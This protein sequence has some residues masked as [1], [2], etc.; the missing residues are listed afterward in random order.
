M[1]SRLVTVVGLMLAGLLVV[2]GVALSQGPGMWVEY[3]GNPI[4]D[5]LEADAYYPTVLHDP[6]SSPF[7]G[8]GEASPFKMW[9]DSDLQ[10]LVSDDGI[11]WTKVGDML[12]GTVTGLPDGKVRH[13]LVEYYA[14][15]FAGGNDGTNPSGATMYYR[16]WFWHTD[17]LYD[18]AA[19]HYAESP[20]GRAWYNLQ[21]LQNGAVPIVTGD[22]PD[23]HRGSYGPCDVLYHPG[24]SNTGTDW[25]FWMY[26]DGT[27]GGDEAIG[28]GFSADG[29]IWTGYDAN[30]DGNAEPVM[31]GTYIAGGWDENY[32]S[33]ATVWRQGPTDYRMWYS[34]GIDTMNHGIGYA[35]SIDGFNWTRDPDNPIFH[36]DD[37]G[38]PWRVSRTYTPAVVRVGNLWLMW[39]SGENGG[40][41][42][43]GVTYAGAGAPEPSPE[44]DKTVDP[45]RIAVGQETTF[46]ITVSNSTPDTAHDIVVTDEIDPGLEIV[47][48]QTT[49][50]MP[51][52]AGQLV[53]VDVA[54]L[55]PDETMI[56]SI[57]VRAHA[58]GY[59]SNVAH[60]TA[61]GGEDYSEALLTVVAAEEEFVPEAG[62]LLLLSGGL[63]GLAGYATLRRRQRNERC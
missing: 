1:K 6:S 50:G 46:T 15:G 57:L 44:V 49:K 53:T 35:T 30:S 58:E 45:A 48:V 25:A 28:L 21:P 54:Q 63:A 10:Y 26:Y 39:Y 60:V 13:P 24:A 40:G 11:S 8:H 32:V 14:D 4:I 23:W 43:I 20:D 37:P 12:D 33:R 42:A 16:L 38:Y 55:A 51:S 61:A 52:V 31:N 3:A 19:L 34:A 18:V 9:H 22:W 5:P 41:K 27:T 59:V 62:S 56:I 29:V 36:K 47:E 2:P 7:G 17:Y